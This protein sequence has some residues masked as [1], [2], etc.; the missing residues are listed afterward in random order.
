MRIRMTLLLVAIV[1]M[2]AFAA[3][4]WSE[5]VHPAQL[6]WGWGTAEAPLGLVLLALLAL[7][8]LG[9][10]V[11]SA[12]LETHYQ[13]SA[14]RNAKLLE[15]QRALADKAEASRFIELRTYLESQAAMASQRE[16]AVA[17][18]LELAV[19]REQRELLAA[20]DRLSAKLSLYPG[21]VARTAGLKHDSLAPH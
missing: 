3:L 6:S 9:F 14:H 10:L 4:N 8:W 5:F 16:A 1:L 2:A 11:G 15:V 17:T 18:K 12:F 20:I 13:L 21:E 7:S 19:T